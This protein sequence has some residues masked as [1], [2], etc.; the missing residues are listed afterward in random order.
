MVQFMD[1]LRERVTQG[2]KIDDVLILVQRTIHVDR[3]P[4]VV[5]M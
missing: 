4:V 5:P 3:D 1:K 2:D